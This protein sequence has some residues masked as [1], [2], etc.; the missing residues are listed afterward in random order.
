MVRRAIIPLCVVVAALLPSGPAGAGRAFKPLVFEGGAL[1][2]AHVQASDG[3]VSEAGFLALEAK[4]GRTLAIDHYYRPWATTFPDGRERWN[5]DHGRTPMISWGKANTGEIARGDHDRLIQIRARAV[6][7]LDRPVFLRWFWEMDGK[8]NGEGPPYDVAAPDYIAAWRHIRAIFDAE[9]AH[10]VSW[11]WCPNAWGFTIGKA[12]AYYPGD[13]SVD[14]ICA[15]GYNW[16]PNRPRSRYETFKTVFK[17]FYDWAA[18]RPKPLMIGEWG[19]QEMGPGEKARWLVDAGNTLK[20]DFPNVAAVVYFNHTGHP[21]EGNHIDWRVETSPESLVAFSALAQ[22]P[23]FN[24]APGT[25]PG[26]PPV[27]PEAPWPAL[28]P[29]TGLAALA[30]TL[31]RH[32]KAWRVAPG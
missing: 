26:P 28:L 29:V 1:L 24:P 17:A 12:Q 8:Q 19:A 11:V 30:V 7:A 14:W 21:N 20:T 2:G 31:A 16:F 4:L 5:F 13:D 32:R 15:D 10:N 18:A 23:Y 3:R 25:D 22:D 6:A 27:I 9:G